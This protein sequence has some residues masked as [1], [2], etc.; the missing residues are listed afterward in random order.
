MEYRTRAKSGAL[1][2]LYHKGA[3]VRIEHGHS[4]WKNPGGPGMAT[5]FKWTL[6][7][8]FTAAEPQ[9]PAPKAATAAGF[10]G[11]LFEGEI[12]P[13]VTITPPASAKAGDS[14][15]LEVSINALVC[16]EN[17]LF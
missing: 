4:Y 5:K 14:V 13:L 6:P 11:Y 8:G 7:E 9:W 1:V 10:I 16:I 17:C 3:E 2:W 12:A 15:A